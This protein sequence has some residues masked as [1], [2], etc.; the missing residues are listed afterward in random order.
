M[1]WQ[2]VSKSV[3]LIITSPDDGT[4]PKKAI[5]LNDDWI[6]KIIIVDCLH[7]SSGI[8]VVVV[9]WSMAGTERSQ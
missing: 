3:S 1:T 6:I 9:K 7:R 8:V 2:K 5:T 4:P